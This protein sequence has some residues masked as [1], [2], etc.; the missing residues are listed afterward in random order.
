M[1]D[2]IQ[3]A[4]ISASG[5]AVTA[6]IGGFILMKQAKANQ[7]LKETA[8]KVDG[9]LSDFADKMVAAIREKE[10]AQGELA[11]RDFTR[12]HIEEREDKLAESGKA[13]VLGKSES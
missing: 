1:T 2:A 12:A 4:L 13:P 6:L 3:V 10:H 11:G 8:E 9:H 5:S 7:I